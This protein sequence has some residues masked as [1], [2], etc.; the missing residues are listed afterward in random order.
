M[1]SSVETRYPFLDESVFAFL[2]RVPPRYK[3]RGLLGDKYLLRR[4]AE[5]WVPHS[6]AWRQ[7]AMFRAPFD[8]FHLDVAPPFVEQLLGEEALRKTG[9]FDAASVLHW[10]RRFR[11]IRLNPAKRLSI[12]MGLVGVLATQ[13]WHH[14]YIGG[15]CELPVYEP[16]LAPRLAS[17]HVA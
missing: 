9:Y 6:I 17:A 7:K 14:S 10:R 4:V 12:E 5:R 3:L 2:A 15:L 8:S 1:N 13:L 11:S 16:P